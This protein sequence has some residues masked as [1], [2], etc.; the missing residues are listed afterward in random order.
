MEFPEGVGVQANKSS[1]GGEWIFSGTIQ[2][3][4]LHRCKLN[5][6]DKLKRLSVF[7]ELFHCFV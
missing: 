4:D 3:E 1:A 6:N 5:A 2:S 7:T